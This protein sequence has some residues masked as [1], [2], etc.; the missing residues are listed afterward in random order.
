[1][2]ASTVAARPQA[3]TGAGQRAAA[4]RALACVEAARLVRHPAFL[5]GLAAT[6]LLLQRPGE[7]AWAGEG[8]YLA[9]ISWTF[10][11]M[12]TMAA[13]ALGAGR[14]RL[15]SE[16]DLFPAAPVDARDRVMAAALALAGP[17]VVAAVLVAGLAALNAARGGY[18]LGEEPYERV[19]VPPFVEWA[20]PVLLLVL[21]GVV[22]V[23]V[24][25]LRRARVAALALLMFTTFLGATIVWAFQ[26][27]PVRVLHPAMYPSYEHQLAPSFDPATWSPG[28]PPL[29]PPDEWT[30][31]WREVRFD[32]AALGWHLVYVIGLGL[33][34]TWWAVRA[35][36]RRERPAVP[37]PP[38]WL[39]RAGLPLLLGA[40]VAQIVTAGVNR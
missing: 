19:V 9:A 8:Y 10:A 2:S 17:A 14:Q 40:G 28:D 36:A 31:T 38:A 22:G 29:L 13:A 16:P 25:Q 12:G 15:Q 35:A 4:V 32:T 11:W 33:V 37:P 6:V 18:L 3:A 21:A 1:M 5:F 30:D 20:Q 26:V 7:E 39:L 23:A 27:H 34:A 24:A